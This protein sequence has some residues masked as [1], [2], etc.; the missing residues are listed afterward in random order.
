M[1]VA[2]FIIH[3][4]EKH[5]TLPAF[6]RVLA[7]NGAEFSDSFVENLLRI[8]QHMRP[9]LNS[10]SSCTSKYIN[11]KADT[12]AEKF[13]GLAIPNEPQVPF[14]DD[15]K[16]ETSI[17][18][19]REIVNDLMAQF[20]AD[21]P[22]FKKEEDEQKLTIRQS[23]SRDKKERRERGE[24]RSRNKNRSRSRDRN[25]NN[26]HISKDKRRGRSRSRHRRI[27]SD[28]N[29]RRSRSRDRRHSSK[30]RNREKN[31]YS[32]IRHMRKED[33]DVFDDDPITGKVFFLHK[34]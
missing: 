1:F 8:I 32:M 25:R 21:A 23:S 18:T 19:D 7:E 24:N 20:E 34:F 12:L 16:E 13:P 30:E 6:K 15:E 17:A 3:L 10:N 22:S 27:S 14:K 29:G 9:N 31:S 28:R 26:R 4:S 5:N 33:I 2:E 11:P